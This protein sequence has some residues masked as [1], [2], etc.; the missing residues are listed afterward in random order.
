MA[1]RD[2]NPVDALVRSHAPL[3]SY[4]VT[5]VAPRLPD[6]GHLGAL[7]AAGLEA[8]S[9]AAATYDASGRDGTGFAAFAKPRITAA[10]AGALADDT[11]TIPG[12]APDAAVAELLSHMESTSRHDDLL[13]AAHPAAFAVP[14][15]GVR[16]Q[17]GHYAAVAAAS[18]FRTHL[19]SEALQQ[20]NAA[21]L[22]A[23][24]T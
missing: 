20:P 24:G 16:R 17:A 4:A 3:V 12:S 23:F 9:A 6:P 2:H 11:A 1:T 5:A 8:L 7:T 21:Q 18:D 13:A 14:S 10:L 22:R 15:P 19:D